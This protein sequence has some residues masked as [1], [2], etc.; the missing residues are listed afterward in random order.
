MKITKITSSNKTVNLNE[1]HPWCPDKNA[2]NQYLEIDIGAYGVV[3]AVRAVDNLNASRM[4]AKSYQLE[5][6]M[7]GKEWL[8]YKENNVTKVLFFV[9][10]VQVIQESL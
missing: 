8:T 1:G 5:F 2:N 7:D 9:D 4:K 6:S 10:L 3:C